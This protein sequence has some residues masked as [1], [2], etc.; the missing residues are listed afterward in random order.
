[1][2]QSYVYIMASCRN[3]TLYIGV[4]S[5]LIKRVWEHR[6]S[7]VKSFTKRNEVCDLVYYE[8]HFDIEEAI[9]REKN[10]KAWKRNWKLR[11][12]EKMNP[13]WEDLFEKIVK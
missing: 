5:D 2:R 3:G 13:G 4:T 7:L 10:L 6:N 12:I 8:I 9:K 11:L 1:M